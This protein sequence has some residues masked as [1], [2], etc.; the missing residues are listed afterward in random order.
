MKTSKIN[1]KIKTTANTKVKLVCTSS[2]K[3]YN[4][5]FRYEV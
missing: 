5:T 4:T 1:L 2:D 3:K